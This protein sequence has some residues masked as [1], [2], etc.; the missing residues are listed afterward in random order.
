MFKIDNDTHM[1]RKPVPIGFSENMAL[2]MAVIGI[3]TNTDVEL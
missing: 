1:C 2:K 3:E